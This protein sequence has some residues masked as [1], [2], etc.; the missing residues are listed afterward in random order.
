[1]E[2]ISFTR[3][4]EGPNGLNLIRG[5]IYSGRRVFC[6]HLII[7]NPGTQYSAS[8]IAIALFLSSPSLESVLKIQTFATFIT[9]QVYP[10]SFSMKLVSEMKRM[11]ISSRPNARLPISFTSAFSSSFRSN[12]PSKGCLS[13]QTLIL[14]TKLSLPS[15]CFRT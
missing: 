7:L 9:F 5:D 3:L 6:L 8:L 13:R 1:M 12:E 4:M 15:F 2:S 10:L 14:T 11:F